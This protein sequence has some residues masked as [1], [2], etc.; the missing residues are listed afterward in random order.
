[1]SL[2]ELALLH[3]RLRLL[4]SSKSSKA[5]RDLQRKPKKPPEGDT[6]QN[7]GI[8]PPASNGRRQRSEV[9]LSNVREPITKF[10]TVIILRAEETLLDGTVKLLL[11]KRSLDCKSMSNQVRKPV[12]HCRRFTTIAAG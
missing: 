2:L 12:V 8:L 9:S 6:P 7:C 3:F 4:S 11:A 10:E 5:R 1:V